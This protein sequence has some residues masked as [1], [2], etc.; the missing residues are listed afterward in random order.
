MDGEYT[1]VLAEAVP[2]EG[3]ARELK[4]AGL[5]V[6]EAVG[7][8]DLAADLCLAMPVDAVAVGPVAFAR[9][10]TRFT[11]RLNAFTPL[12]RPSV[13]VASVDGSATVEYGSLI[14]GADGLVSAA[15]YAASLRKRPE[16][17]DR[18]DA[19]C[20]L[21]ELGVTEYTDGFD[22]LMYALLLEKPWSLAKELYVDLAVMG[23]TG[24]SNAERSLR[25]AISAGRSKRGR[26]WEL[27]AGG[28]KGNM[29]TVKALREVLYGHIAGRKGDA[30]QSPG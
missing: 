11:V 27:C 10:G 22:S 8:L 21:R 4:D 18:N 25:Y 26:L 29:Q 15:E 20:L 5:H 3:W 6:V 13:A 1:V 7:P 12:F 16:K 17:V 24:L 14:R 23:N 28:A 9:D 2:A 19:R 30:A